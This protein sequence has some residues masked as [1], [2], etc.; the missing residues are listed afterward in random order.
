MSFVCLFPRPMVECTLILAFLLGN[1]PLTTRRL[2]TFIR[3]SVVFRAKEEIPH[4]KEGR[5]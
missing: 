3:K 4:S 2:N 1:H 5:M